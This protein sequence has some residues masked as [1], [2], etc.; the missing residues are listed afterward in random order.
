MN[1]TI[2]SSIV[3][4]ALKSP[5][6]VLTILAAP[7]FSSESSKKLEIEVNKRPLFTES[8]TKVKT[9]PTL[10]AIIKFFLLS[11]TGALFSYHLG[12]K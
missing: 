8:A 4:N 3:S 12:K 2:T 9:S 11:P 7:A 1:K 6:I 10:A 5:K